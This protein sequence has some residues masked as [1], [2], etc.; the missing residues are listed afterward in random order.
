MSLKDMGKAIGLLGKVDLGK[1]AELDEKVDL[2]ELMAVVFVSRDALAE[3]LDAVATG[4]HSD[5]ESLRHDDEAVARA[6]ERE[7]VRE[8]V[9]AAI[10]DAQQDLPKWSQARRVALVADDLTR[11]EGML[12]PK[13]SKQRPRVRQAYQRE[14]DSL[15][16]R[17]EALLERSSL[18]DV[19]PA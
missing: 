4:Q 13:L 8:A 19:T 12:T 3:H 9:R 11:E 2:A 1:L 18:L 14:V 10:R 16:D 5:G 7:D 17:N 15:Y 6:L